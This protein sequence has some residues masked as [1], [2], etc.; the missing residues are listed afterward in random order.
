MARALIAAIEA[1][2]AYVDLASDFQVRDGAGDAGKQAALI[3]QAKLLV[4][5][6]IARGKTVGWQAWLTYHN[7][8]KAPDLLGPL[9]SRALG[10]PYLQV[11]STRARKRLIGPWQ[12]FAQASEDACDAADVIFYFTARDA[13]DLRAYAPASQYLV[14]L[15]PFLAQ[16]DLPAVSRGTSMLAVGM[17]RRPDKLA[18]YALIAQ[19]LALMN[20]AEWHLNI[21]GD[22]P[23]QTEVKALMVPFGAQVSFL[24]KLDAAGMARAYLD[25][26][27]LF[28]PGVNEAFGL[29]YLEAQ[30]YGL[31][32]VAQD[33]PGV[34]DVVFPRAYP[35][36]DE[37]PEGLLK[38]LRAPAPEAAEVREFIAAHHLLTSAR[39]TIKNG[40][41]KAGIQ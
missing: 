16:T 26:R 32:V 1:G 33:R 7:Y 40:L 8:Y 28:W 38:C 41:A 17:M 20:D 36:P 4:P 13:D 11:E 14:H 25:A 27:L 31:A 19:T 29:S 15:S 23:A 24:G 9:V 35:A 2:G 30:S 12:A 6:L 22:G 39:D 18:S 37:G 3:A 21:A 34:R 10:I 5:D